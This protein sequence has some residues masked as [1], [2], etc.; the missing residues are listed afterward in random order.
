MRNRTIR[1]NLRLRRLD[2]RVCAKEQNARMTACWDT[3]V[4]KEM[5]RR[6]KGKSRRR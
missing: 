4:V 3:P 6:V 2:L 1:F 5:A